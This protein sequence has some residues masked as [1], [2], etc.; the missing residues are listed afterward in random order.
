[1][2]NLMQ[3]HKFVVFMDASDLNLGQVQLEIEN[4]NFLKQFKGSKV[5]LEPKEGYSGYF[6]L[7]ITMPKEGLGGT[8]GSSVNMFIDDLIME[9]VWFKKYPY[10]DK[11]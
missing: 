11:T 3:D 6:N 9:G 10:V 7:T 5:K 1:M 8:F 2:D 4:N